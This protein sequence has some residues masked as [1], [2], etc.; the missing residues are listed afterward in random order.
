MVRCQ[1]TVNPL[2]PLS[3]AADGEAMGSAPPGEV[4]TLAGDLIPFPQLSGR[5]ALAFRPLFIFKIFKPDRGVRRGWTDWTAA[6]PSRSR[7]DCA[8]RMPEWRRWE[9]APFGTTGSR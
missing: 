2:R 4:F 8:S 1:R 3:G 5:G 6:A 7:R 9:Y